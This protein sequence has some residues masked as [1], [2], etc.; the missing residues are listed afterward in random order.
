M[1]QSSV[2]RGLENGEVEEGAITDG[3][4]WVSQAKKWFPRKAT[5]AGLQIGCL[6]KVTWQHEI[7]PGGRQFRDQGQRMLFRVR[8]SKLSST[9]DGLKE[10]IRETLVR[11]RD[12]PWYQ[13]SEP[14]DL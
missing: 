4:R 6:R 5:R 3:P 1:R 2:R 14:G 12:G 11:R 9:G 7:S 13:M 10:L 8:N